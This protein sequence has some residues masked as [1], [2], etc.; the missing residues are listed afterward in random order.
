MNSNYILGC[1]DSYQLQIIWTYQFKSKNYS[2][3]QNTKL[4]VIR[5]KVKN[6]QLLD[7]NV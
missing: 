6:I 1:S 7:T 3:R 4:K 5:V 2:L